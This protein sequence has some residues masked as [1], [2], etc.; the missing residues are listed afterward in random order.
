[1]EFIEIGSLALAV[2]GSLVALLSRS[3]KGGSPAGFTTFSD[4]ASGKGILGGFALLVLAYG[5]F[6][7]VSYWDEIVR[8]SADATYLAGL[9]LSMVA[10]MFVQ[11]MTSNYKAGK[12]LLDVTASDL[13]L[14]LL[15]SIVVFYPIWALTR[16][17]EP[18]FFG[19]YAAF[20][21]GYFWQRIVEAAKPPGPNPGPNP[22]PPPPN[23]P[24]GA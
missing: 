8:N 18:G 22:N 13:L 9:A 16:E 4:G 14:P 15:F 5:A 20:L 19:I 10:G 7:V 17:S 12:P 11:V 3:L 23:P 21:N 6:V 24:P 2:L 1:M